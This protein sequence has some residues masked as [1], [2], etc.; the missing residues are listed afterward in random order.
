MFHPVDKYSNTDCLTIDIRDGEPDTD[1]I[2]QAKITDKNGIIRRD[3]SVTG[4][5]LKFDKLSADGDFSIGPMKLPAP[6]TLVTGDGGYSTNSPTMNWPIPSETPFDNN[7]LFDY[8]LNVKIDAYSPK[9]YQWKD[10]AVKKLDVDQRQADWY[11]IGT[12]EFTITTPFSYEDNFNMKSFKSGTGPLWFKITGAPAGAKVTYDYK[13]IDATG[14]VFHQNPADTPYTFWANVDANGVY[15]IRTDSRF[16][17][18]GGTKTTSLFRKDGRVLK[19]PHTFSENIYIEWKGKQ[20]KVA[21]NVIWYIT[22]P[23]VLNCSAQGVTGYPPREIYSA[24]TTRVPWTITGGE[25]GANWSYDVEFFDRYNSRIFSKYNE[26]PSG[27]FDSTGTLTGNG[28]IDGAGD[29]GIPT[30]HLINYPIKAAYQIYMYTGADKIA[31]GPI[32]YYIGKPQQRLQASTSGIT[33]SNSTGAT[34]SLTVWFGPANSSCTYT[35]TWSSSKKTQM[36]QS[37]TSPNTTDAYGHIT[38]S[39]TYG[40]GAFTWLLG[41]E[42]STPPASN[43]G[44]V[45]P[46]TETWVFTVGGI[47]Y[48]HV[49]TIT[50]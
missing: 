16:A 32:T 4:W 30:P 15:D 31:L 5:A 46:I 35:R 11:K 36:V 3:D 9:K 25:P 41:P 33:F 20:I 39:I 47:Q 13:G 12:T 17:A 44:H 29:H 22:F 42:G 7:W 34:I 50:A 43:Q 27:V 49:S 38:F 19:W 10:Q 45:F 21:N 1:L 37:G 40:P 8:P 18:D 2:L 6:S 26:V 14:F 48:T 24:S 23:T 28:T